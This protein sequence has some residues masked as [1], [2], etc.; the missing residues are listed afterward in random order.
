MVKSRVQKIQ[1]EVSNG[2]GDKLTVSLEGGVTREKV[3]QLLDII[4][5]MGGIS[6]RVVRSIVKKSKFARIFEII[7]N[8]HSAFDWFSSKNVKSEYEKEFGEKIEQSTVSTYLS[9]LSSMRLLVK[10]GSRRSWKYRCIAPRK[11]LSP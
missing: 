2:D 1:I 5:L 3:V 6:G 7:R 11:L 8:H 9:R 4:D 10:A